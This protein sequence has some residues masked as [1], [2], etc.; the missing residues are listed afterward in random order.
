MAPYAAR[1]CR[2]LP[3][4]GEEPRLA[5]RP[6]K[7]RGETVTGTAGV[8]ARILAFF[9]KALAVLVI[10][11]IAGEAF[12]FFLYPQVISC[13]RPERA[14][15][16][17]FW[18]PDGATIVHQRH[19]KWKF[20]YTINEDRCRGRRVMVSNEYTEPNVVVLGDS[21]AMGIGVNDGEE[22]PAVL[23]DRLGSE[24]NVINTG[25][26]GWGLTQ[27][28]RR[29]YEFGQ[30]YS[31]AVVVL[32][33]SGNDPGDNIA[34]RAAT[35]EN[36]RFAFHNAGGRGSW[37]ARTLSQS[38]LVQHSQIYNLIK[39]TVVAFRN[40]R[41]AKAMGADDGG[42]GVKTETA[43]PYETYYNELLG[44]LAQD[45]QRRGVR[46]IMI[47]VCDQLATFP[48]I[49]AGVTDLRDR[50]LIEYYPTAE[51][52]QDIR[53]PGSPEGH[54]WGVEAHRRVGER[55]ADIIR[56]N[57]AAAQRPD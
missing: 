42:A 3:E 30:L 57:T 35:V 36:G 13:P 14:P 18:L 51:W 20:T 11:F 15:G 56:S 47:D 34:Y 4:A 2:S 6:P 44:L 17:C 33:F 40:A 45:L 43:R 38:R 32:Q 29:Y 27:E 25:C 23:D 54:R 41:L 28:I 1:G 50:G 9:L 49:K 8:G 24:Y 22:F 26:A 16:Y 48:Y 31:P 12:L 55:L 52:L 53:D 5:G 37:V 7:D 46:L 10:A 21:Y 39:N 19:G